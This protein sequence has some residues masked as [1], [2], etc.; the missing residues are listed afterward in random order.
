[1]GSPSVPKLEVMT[2]VYRFSA[3]TKR[4]WAGGSVKLSETNSDETT[5]NPDSWIIARFV[6]VSY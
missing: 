3:R 6:S 1:M 2:L 5:A 4:C